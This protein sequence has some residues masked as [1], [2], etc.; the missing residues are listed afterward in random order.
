[1]LLL[2][3]Q[4]V[5][6]RRLLIIMITYNYKCGMAEIYI[7]TFTPLIHVLST[8]DASH[9]AMGR[10]TLIAQLLTLGVDKHIQGT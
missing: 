4:V 9:G 8:L 2:F 10:I 1:M 7:G 5:K 6:P 3:G